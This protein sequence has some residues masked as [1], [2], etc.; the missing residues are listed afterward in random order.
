[1]KEGYELVIDEQVKVTAKTALGTFWSTRSMLQILEQDAT[2]SKIQK[3]FA[4]DLPK[5]EVR[6]WF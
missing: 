5:Y 6:S 3:G 1:M 2:H 4:K